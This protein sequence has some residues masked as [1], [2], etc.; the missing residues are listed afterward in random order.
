MPD[1][2]LFSKNERL[3]EFEAIFR[4]SGEVRMTIKADDLEAAKA[5]ARVR[6]E[7][8]EFGLELDETTDVQ[9]SYVRKVP[10][11]FR[12]TRGG[13]KMQVSHLLEGDE[14]REPDDR[15]F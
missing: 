3:G 12:V 9:L 2:A 15:G 14:P 4:I 1:E 13:R 7:D 8:E 5:Q 6:S 11:M 10:A